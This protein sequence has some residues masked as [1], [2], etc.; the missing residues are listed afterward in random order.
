M[1]IIYLDNAS[2]SYPKPQ[3]VKECLAT[4]YDQPIGSYGRTPDDRTL[5]ISAEVERL[6][7][8]LNSRVGGVE[9]SHIVFCY[10][11][12]EALN[13]IALGLPNLCKEEVIISPMEHNAVTRPLER[14]PGNQYTVMPCHSDGKVD[15]ERLYPMLKKKGD[16]KL[17]IVNGMSNVN[18]VVQPLEEICRCIKVYRPD[19][20][21]AI[22]AAQYLPYMYMNAVEWGIDFVAISGHKGWLGPTGIAALYVSRPETL[23][24]VVRGGTGYRSEWQGVVPHLPEKYEVGT[25]NML[26]AVA[27]MAALDEPLNPLITPEVL[28]DILKEIRPMGYRVYSAVERDGQGPL[29][30]VTSPTL[31]PGVLADELWQRAQIIV[32]SGLHCAPLAHRTLDTLPSGT[33]RISLSPFTTTE[34]MTLLCQSL[35]ALR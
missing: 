21:I 20:L 15:V 27:W 23:D 6:R 7:D 12:T 11:A 29:F 2:T 26:G 9:G 1:S 17:A 33:V 34:E 24:P 16:L 3:K 32:R 30:S 14:L 25:L 5:E 13:R 4:F 19:C 35:H 18:G 28:Q 31:S 10:N 8:T 22:D